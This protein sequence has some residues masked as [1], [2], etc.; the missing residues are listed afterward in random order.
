MFG[1]VTI[2]LGIGPHSSLTCFDIAGITA[3]FCVG[4]QMNIQT[5]QE[6]GF[7]R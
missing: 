1:R 7:S 5:L 2:T 6:H 3:E 4:D